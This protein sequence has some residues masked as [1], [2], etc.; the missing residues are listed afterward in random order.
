M[1][2]VQME[3]FEQFTPLTL[4]KP[5][6]WSQF[7]SRTQRRGRSVADSV[8]DYHLT[9]MKCTNLKVEE[10][11]I[12]SDHKLVTCQV[13]PSHTQE[14][15]EELNKDVIRKHLGSKGTIKIMMDSRWPIIPF[16][17]IAK[18]MGLCKVHKICPDEAHTLVA[19]YKKI[20]RNM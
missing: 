1:N 20:A 15:L 2:P 14:G 17:G 10:C 9:E 5:V 13:E 16:I 18:R 4:A 7:I 6:D 19:D 11:G 8:L 3:E 12:D